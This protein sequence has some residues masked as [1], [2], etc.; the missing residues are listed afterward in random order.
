VPGRGRT[1]RGC[2]GD[3]SKLRP[4]PE[5]QGACGPCCLRD[6][7]PCPCHLA[8]FRSRTPRRAGRGSRRRP[9]TAARRSRRCSRPRPSTCAARV[10]RSAS[11]LRST[12]SEAARWRGRARGRGSRGLSRCVALTDRVAGAT[13]F[14]TRRLAPISPPAQGSSSSARPLRCPPAASSSWSTSSRH[15]RRGGGGRGLRVAFQVSQPA[16]WRRALQSLPA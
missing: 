12:A 15:T 1:A 11:A 9:S 16:G 3:W 8:S 5:G 10:T 4:L 6:C 13:W 2:A 14:L 7:R